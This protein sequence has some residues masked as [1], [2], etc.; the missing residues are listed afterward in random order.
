MGLTYASFLVRSSST[1]AGRN[2]GQ[3]GH[4]S[5]QLDLVDDVHHHITLIFKLCFRSEASQEER[6]A[7]KS[8]SSSSRKS[9]SDVERCNSAW[10][11]CYV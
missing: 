5:W 8:S 6:T 9:T 3:I 1:T 7:G 4:V 2:P 10:I 11:I